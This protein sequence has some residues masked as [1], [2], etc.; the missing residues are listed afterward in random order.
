MQKIALKGI[1]HA[2]TLYTG[3]GFRKKSGCRIVESDC[4][5]I[6]DG[7]M[8]FETP[9]NQA[10][11]KGQ[12]SVSQNSSQF[13]L[14][15]WVGKSNEIPEEFQSID[16]IDL[17]QKQF[18]SAGWADC[19]TH[20]VFGGDRSQEFARRCSGE[21]YEE[22][23]KKGGGIQYT[24]QETRKASRK[25]LFESALQRVE[26]MERYGVRIIEIKS[27][28][29]LDWATERKCLLVIEDLRKARPDLFFVSTF[30]GAHAYPKEISK[31]QYLRMLIEEMLPLVKDEGLA[32]A[33]DVFIDRGYFS[34]GEAVQICQKAR[35]LG[36][37]IRLHGDELECN[38][39]ASFAVSEEP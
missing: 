34:L 9:T 31:E 28:Y 36:L 39:V 8:V 20:L 19:H 2:S 32:S 37:A 22:I 11:S 25:Q 33:C 35:D 30:M 10:A 21:S 24:V 4:G 27:G 29:G 23:A 3:E 26:T 5:S 15:R 13:G 14:I 18:V 12:L 38:E 16:W 7:A 6:V 17:D 1:K